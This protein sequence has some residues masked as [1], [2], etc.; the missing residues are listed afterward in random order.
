[1][2]TKDGFDPT[3]HSTS[4]GFSFPYAPSPDIIRTHQKDAYFTTVLNTHLSTI[5]RSLYGARLTQTRATETKTASDLLYLALTTLIGNRTLGEEYCDVVQ[6]EARSGGSVTDGLPGVRKRAGYVAASVLVP[7]AMG[8]MLPVLRRRL[9]GLLERSL[10]R[11]QQQR[12]IREKGSPQQWAPRS[13]KLLSLQRYL[14]TH[15]DT[16]TSPAPIYALSL[17]TFYFTG[18]YYHLSKRLFNLRYILT[19]QLQPSDE[20]A[21]YEVLGVL[22]VLQLVVQGY[23]HVQETVSATP[24]ANTALTGVTPDVVAVDTAQNRSGDALLVGSAIE[25]QRTDAQ[26]SKL[27]RIMHT[28]NSADPRIDLANKQQMMWLNGRQARKC[29]LCLEA[30][31]DPATTTCGHIFC[32]SCICDWCRE[33]PE[34]PLCRQGCGVQHVLL[35]RG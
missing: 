28:S 5:L 34:C 13:S 29:T 2:T 32:W 7:Y 4:T 16:L 20:R 23:L 25:P 6:V 11:A 33:K 8:R 10:V 15:I 19:R 3:V 1:M 17:A 35:L 14:L 21:G 12:Q 18:A 24:E 31:K 26:S 30:M 9:R 27:S 22:M